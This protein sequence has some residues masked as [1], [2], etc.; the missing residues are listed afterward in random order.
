[1]DTRY[2]AYPQHFAMRSPIN[3]YLLTLDIIF[4]PEQISVHLPN[5]ELISKIYELHLMVF[6][7]AH[8]SDIPL[9]FWYSYSVEVIVFSPKNLMILRNMSRRDFM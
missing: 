4:N 9:L 3:I 1:M 2:R 5:A 8:Q 6:D 7:T